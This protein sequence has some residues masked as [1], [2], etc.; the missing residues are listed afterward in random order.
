MMT[1]KIGWLVV[2]VAT[3]SAVPAMAQDKKAE[4]SI[5]LG[6]TFSDGV[7]GNSVAAGDGNV[8]NRIDPK[9]S[10]KWGVDV[11]FFTSEQVEVG[12]LFTQQ[13][14]KLTLGG[15]NTKEVGDMKIANY[16][17]YLAYNFYDNSSKVRPYFFGGMGATHF[18]SVPFTRVGVGA[19]S[20]FAETQFSTTWGA[21]VKMFPAPGI[22]VRVGAQWTPV[23][24]KSDAAGWWCDPWW[25][26][27]LVGNAQYSNQFDITGGISFRF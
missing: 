1:R 9:D 24:I 16:H 11:G 4:A 12:F 13:M 17:G 7:S 19:S 20:T 3:M 2:L 21:G 6:W 25:G 15:T 10:F 26:C 8:Y 22:G 14:S 5:L 27:Y 23:Y 18:P